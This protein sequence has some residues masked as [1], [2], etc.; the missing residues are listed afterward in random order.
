MYCVHHM[1]PNVVDKD[2]DCDC[3]PS[4]HRSRHTG[5]RR[6]VRL[7]EEEQDEEV[8][9]EDDEPMLSVTVWKYTR[10]FKKKRGSNPEKN[11]RRSTR[12]RRQSLTS[13]DVGF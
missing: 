3:Q 1:F 5:T 4:V 10:I 8:D 12:A 13:I 2:E 6:H 7:E 9:E 11:M